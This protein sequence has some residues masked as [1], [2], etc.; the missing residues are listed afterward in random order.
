M[1]LEQAPAASVL[2]VV[3]IVDGVQRPRIDDQRVASSDLR[4]SSMW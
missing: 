4:I 2:G 3:A 1:V